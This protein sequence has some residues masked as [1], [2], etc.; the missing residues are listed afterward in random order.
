MCPWALSD[1]TG[2]LFAKPARQGFIQRHFIGA[3]QARVTHDEKGV[4]VTPS[5]LP[6]ERFWVMWSMIAG[7][8]ISCRMRS[9]STPDTRASWKMRSSGSG[10]DEDTIAVWKA[11]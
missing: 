8:S 1:R 11:E 9:T 6:S 10:P 3:R 5:T 2:G 4:P 7:S